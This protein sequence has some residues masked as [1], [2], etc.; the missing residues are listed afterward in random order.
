LSQG[1]FL[2]ARVLFAIKKYDKA[3]AEAHIALDLINKLENWE[4]DVSEDD[5]T[6]IQNFHGEITEYFWRNTKYWKVYVE[7][8]I[9]SLW[10]NI[11]KKK[12]GY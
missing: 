12:G 9:R 11:N 5:Y 3:S 6:D 1:Y 4:S 8:N 2:R 10:D 7:P